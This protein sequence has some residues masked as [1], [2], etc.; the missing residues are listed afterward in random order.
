MKVNPITNL[1]ERARNV[2]KSKIFEIDNLTQSIEARKQL[3]TR[4]HIGNMWLNTDDQI[5]GKAHEALLAGRTGYEAIGS[6]IPEFA[7]ALVDYW[8]RKY[9][10]S[11]EKDWII[12]GPTTGLLNQTIDALLQRGRMARIVIPAWD[13]YFSQVSETLAT[14]KYIPMEYSGESWRIPEF[15]GK[16]TD[17]FIVNDP[18]NPTSSVLDEKSRQAIISAVSETKAPIIAD[19][20]YDHLYWDC[21]FKPLLQYDEIFDRTIVVGS[22]SKSHRMAGWRM[23]YLISSDKHLLVTLRKK[24]GKDWCCTPPFIQYA[25]AYGLSSEF[26]PRINTWRDTIKR[27]SRKANEVLRSFGV[28]CAKPEGTIYVFANVRCDSVKFAKRLIEEYGIATLPGK[29]LGENARNWIRLTTVSVPE[30]KL[31]PALETIG[32]VYQSSAKLKTQ[33]TSKALH[34]A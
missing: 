27:T 30:E 16:G 33:V 25:A 23:G 12:A 6:C 8:K 17:L 32:R 24:V 3:V 2:R 7:E 26:E 28:E 9:S 11:I 34:A 19:F 29:F 20:A 22:F 5:I 21:D 15:S 1:S 10:V 31:Y 14:Q 18:N 13:P 4:L